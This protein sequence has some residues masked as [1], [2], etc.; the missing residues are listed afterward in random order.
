M[1]RNSCIHCQQKMASNNP[2]VLIEISQWS[3]KRE[4]EDGG[5]V[6]CE[7]EINYVLKDME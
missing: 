2:I 6:I 1:V 3:L 4:F 5:W 7:D